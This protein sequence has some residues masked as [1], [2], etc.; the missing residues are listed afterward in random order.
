M[1][2]ILN[3]SDSYC[4]NILRFK[5]IVEFYAIK[6]NFKSITS[7]MI[8]YVYLPIRRAEN[9]SLFDTMILNYRIIMFL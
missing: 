8:T 6:I 2:S 5:Y 1:G 4:V 9:S 3:Q 7:I